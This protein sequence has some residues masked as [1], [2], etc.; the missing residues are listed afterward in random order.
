MATSETKRKTTKDT[1]TTNTKDL[2]SQNEALQKQIED[3]K[4]QMELMMRAMTQSQPIEQETKKERNITFINMVPGVFVIKGSKIWEINGQFKSKTFLEREA[5]IIVNNMQNAINNGMLYIADA[6]FVKENDLE[7]VYRQ[8][9]TDK[10]L[11]ELFKESATEFIEVFKSASEG[12]QKLI[13][14]MI[15]SKKENGEFVDANILVEIGKLCG[16]NLLRYGEM[17]EED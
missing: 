11:K 9:L 12:Q 15:K 7:E 3:M 6:Q 5:R 17:E 14:D 4:A 10:Q 8:L 1:E 2:Q 13:V 16:E